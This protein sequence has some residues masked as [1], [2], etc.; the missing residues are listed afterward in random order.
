MVNLKIMPIIS[1]FNKHISFLKS[2]IEKSL[3]KIPINNKPSYL[4]EPIHYIINGKGKRLRPILVHLSGHAYSA[5][6]EDMMK[7][8]MA[9]ELLHNF[10]LVHDDIMD[11]DNF[12][13]GQLTVHKKWD[14]PTAILS[15]D[16]VFI[17]SQLLL[18]GFPEIIHRRF[19]EVSLNICEGQGMDKEF[20]KDT[21]ISMGKYLIMIGK[22]T[23]ALLG[24]CAELGALLAG[25]KKDD[26]HILFEYGLNLGLAFQIQDDLLEI[27]GDESSMGKSLGSDISKKK[28]TAL[29]ILARDDNSQKW[30]SFIDKYSTISDY[31]SY[32]DKNGIKDMVEK[33]IEHYINKANLALD[34]APKSDKN[35][36]ESIKSH[37]E[38]I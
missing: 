35:H 38:A 18:N 21:S 20:E 7:A 22:K 24:L 2:D 37:I 32:F 28:Q 33:S 1:S 36:L 3:K 14:E 4:Y 11:N 6:P 23:G 31:Q 26:A 25:L 29:T 16:G 8:S 17:L 10:T 9:V 27:F 5:D 12:R 15:G 30:L 19:N 13:H 34:S